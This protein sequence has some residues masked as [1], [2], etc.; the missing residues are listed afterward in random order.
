MS[1]QPVEVGGITT[2]C[3][4]SRSPFTWPTTISVSPALNWPM[5]LVLASGLPSA[6][7]LGART[8]VVL[9][10]VRVLPSGDSVTFSLAST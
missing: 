4:F 5:A 8:S 1:I 3:T 6:L 7:M 10:A 9:T 2:L